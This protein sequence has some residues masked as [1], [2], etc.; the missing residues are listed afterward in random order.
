[1]NNAGDGEPTGKDTTGKGGGT[2]CGTGVDDG[3]VSE[4]SPSWASSVPGGIKSAEDGVLVLSVRVWVNTYTMPMITA[5]IIEKETT[6]PSNGNIATMYTGVLQQCNVFA[7]GRPCD[8]T[9]NP[10]SFCRPSNNILNAETS[11]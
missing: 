2:V 7:M 5:S 6:T 8:K 9:R 4:T 3:A 11:V 10:R 1:M